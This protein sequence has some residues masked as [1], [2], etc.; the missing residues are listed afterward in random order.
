[1]LGIWNDSDWNSYIELY[2]T[3]NENNVEF[4]NICFDPFDQFEIMLSF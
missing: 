3:T 4:V 2:S 1:M